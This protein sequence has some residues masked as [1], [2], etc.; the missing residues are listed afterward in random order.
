MS[1]IP[2]AKESAQSAA[3]AI[4]EL[5]SELNLFTDL[6]EEIY[7]RLDNMERAVRT[8]KE[9]DHSDD[10]RKLGESIDRLREGRNRMDFGGFYIRANNALQEA[11]QKLP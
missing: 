9:T 5:R 6:G 1:T 11:W 7:Q 4:M 10:V 3:R 2:N 8:L